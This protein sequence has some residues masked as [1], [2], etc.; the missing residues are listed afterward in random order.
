LIV[1]TPAGNAAFGTAP[2]GWTP[3]VLM[4]GLAVLF[5]LLEE[6]RKWLVRRAS[7]ARQDGERQQAR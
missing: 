2:L 7:G 3:W 4:A 5:G 6:L 1:Y